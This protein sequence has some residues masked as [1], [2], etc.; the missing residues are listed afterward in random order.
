MKLPS[1]GQDASAA[2][3]RWDRRKFLTTSG[4]ALSHLAWSG[5]TSSRAERSPIEEVVVV[6]AGIAGLTA[7]YRLLQ[8]GVPV[9]ILEAQERVGGRIWTLREQFAE[10]Q[11][12]EL[13]GDRIDS[14]SLRVAALCRALGLELEDLWQDGPHLRP[15][16]LFGGAR[17]GEAEILRSL[18]SIAERLTSDRSLILPYGTPSYRNPGGSFLDRLSLEQWLELAGAEGWIRDLLAVAYGAEGGRGPGEQS[19]LNLVTRL[20]PGGQNLRL[21]G[22]RDGRFRVRGGNDRLIAA[23][24]ARLGGRI[25]TGTVLE[26]VRRRA[27][28]SLALS[29]RQGASVRV[30][31]APYAIVT[32]PFSTLRRVELDV[33]L[34]PVKQRA[35]DE[36]AYGDHA[37]LVLGFGQRTWRQQGLNGA[38]WS[39]RPRQRVAEAS[40]GQAGRAGILTPDAWGAGRRQVVAGPVATRADAALRQ[41]APLFGDLAAAHRPPAVRF[42]WQSFEWSQGS[43]SC[44]AP[45]QWTIFGGSEGER[46]G[47]LLFAGEHCSRIAPGSIEGGCETGWAAAEALLVDFGLLAPPRRRGA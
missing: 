24:A 11:F 31:S 28:G 25:A 4:L 26:A 19:A 22:R 45:G 35:I 30:V 8:A 47:R 18:G 44:Y 33:D 41:W 13:G 7:A 38:L 42:D 34:P 46:H 39:D 1:N 14:G 10:G 29:V 16:F 15:S 2:S 3:G 23:L 27:D 36:L 5:C 40:R 12:V 17:R 43:V 21:L 37:R 9:R 6:G 32:L 20:E